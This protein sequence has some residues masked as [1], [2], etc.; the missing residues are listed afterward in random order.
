MDNPSE[1]DSIN[2]YLSK[3]CIS[4][5]KLKEFTRRN[6]SSIL[7]LHSGIS[8]EDLKKLTEMRL[9][10]Q[11]IFYDLPISPEEALRRVR[12]E[13][14][15]REAAAAE[16]SE[17]VR[18]RYDRSD[19]RPVYSRGFSHSPVNYRSNRRP[20][21][22]TRYSPMSTPTLSEQQS[23]DVYSRS[24]SEYPYL[25]PYPPQSDSGCRSDSEYEYAN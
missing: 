20:V 1:E 6:E 2:D 22:K 16:Y 11:R 21:D 9:R 3:K 25:T 19:M 17:R 24:R 13:R 12:A 8:V 7:T 14:Y 18:H 15:R 4:L 23:S 10:G 5:D